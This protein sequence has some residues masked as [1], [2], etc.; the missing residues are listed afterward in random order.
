MSKWTHIIGTIEIDVPGNAQYECEYNLQSVLNHLPIVYGSEE[1]M[2]ISAIKKPGYT[3]V[4]SNTDEFDNFSNLAKNGKG[5]WFE[6]QT[7]YLLILNGDLRDTTFETTY[8]SLVKCLCKIAKNFFV[9]FMDILITE[10]NGKKGHIS[11]SIDEDS[12]WTELSFENSDK[13][14]YKMKMEE[15]KYE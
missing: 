2:Y 1:N 5:K 14:A 9:V 6:Y 12:Y 10:D 15:A 7:R 11:C 8:R 13:L 4:S 3:T